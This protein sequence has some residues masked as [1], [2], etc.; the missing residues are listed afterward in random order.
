MVSLS[1]YHLNALKITEQGEQGWHPL[2][3]ALNVLS[4][5]ALVPD[6]LALMLKIILEMEVRMDQKRLENP[7]VYTFIDL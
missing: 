1:A 5:L 3:N 2:Q 4:Q 6:Q 7:S